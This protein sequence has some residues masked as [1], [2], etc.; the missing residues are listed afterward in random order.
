MILA[1]ISNEHISFD[2]SSNV[3]VY[4]IDISMKGSFLTV[5]LRV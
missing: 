4:N 1:L 2:A 3:S 5:Y